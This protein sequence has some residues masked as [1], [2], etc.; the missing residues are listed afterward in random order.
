[1]PSTAMRWNP[2]IT[3]L[4]ERMPRIWKDDATA[5]AAVQKGNVGGEKSFR[6]SEGKEKMIPNLQQLQISES[7]TLDEL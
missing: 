7:V 2:N 1:M 5:A 6:E 4:G 3:R